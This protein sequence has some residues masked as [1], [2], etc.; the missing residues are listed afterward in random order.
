MFFRKAL[1]LLLLFSLLFVSGGCS[2][3]ERLQALREGETS[4]SSEELPELLPEDFQPEEVPQET[5]KVTLYFKDE[6]GRYLVSETREIPKV[7]GIAR[8]AM[9]ALFEGPSSPDLNPVF[10][11]GTQLQDINIRPDGL[12]IVDLSEEATD[13]GGDDPKAEALAVYAV[14]NT[15]TEFPT[16]EKVQILVSGQVRETLAGHIPVDQPL[17]RNLTFVKNY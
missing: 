13:F 17:L 9:E 5:T 10:P 14:V 8:A 3:S 11:V 2:F 12:C 6:E 15:L 16:V 1:V 4:K 7:A